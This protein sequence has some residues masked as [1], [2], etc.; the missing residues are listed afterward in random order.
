MNIITTPRGTTVDTSKV[1]QASFATIL[2]AKGHKVLDTLRVTGKT[3]IY[4]EFGEE[5]TEFE[6]EGT[7]D[8]FFVS[9]DDL[10][11]F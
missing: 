11:Q 1:V 9:E 2:D 7:L 3:A 8:T 4:E 5:K 10:I 6:V